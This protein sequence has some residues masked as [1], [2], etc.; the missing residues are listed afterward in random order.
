MRKLDLLSDSEI[1]KLRICDLKLTLPLKYRVQ[2]E[3]LNSNLKDTGIKWSPHIWFSHEWF[4]PDGTPGFAIPFTLAHPKLMKLEKKFLGSCEGSNPNEFFKL[5]CHE[6][7][8]AIDNAF[9]LRKDKLRHKIFGNPYRNYPSSYRPRPHQK[10]Y[11]HFLG[12]YYA[13]AHPEEDW[14]ETFGHII[15]RKKLKQE[16]TLKLDVK[17]QYIKRTLE[18][19]KGKTPRVKRRVTIEEYKKDKRTVL[20]YFLQKQAQLGLKRKPYFNS[21]IAYVFQNNRKGINLHSYI[22]K[23]KKKISNQLCKHTGEESYYI[24]KSLDD[25]KKVCQNQK[26]KLEYKESTIN[27][28]IER[29]VLENIEDYKKSSYSKIIM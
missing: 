26:I 20:E 23:N 21:K 22:A 11:I 4:S 12:D 19:L 3:K 27:K 24:E 15:A 2:V 5:L 10:D 7:G 13:Q 8:H 17:I 14:A 1:L 29:I 28:R 9:G 16:L 6:T 18:S 25:L